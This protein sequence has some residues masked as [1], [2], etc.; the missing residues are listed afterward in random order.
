VRE[1]TEER[2][3][4]SVLFAD[5]VGFTT[6]SD[7]ADPEDV[8]AAL[9]PYYPRVKREIERVG[10]RV[11]KYIGDAVVGFFGAPLAREDDAERAVRAALAI[12]AAIQELN[13]Q[14]AGLDLA[15]RVAVNTG[16]AMVS[17]GALLE[18]G[19]GMVAGDVVNTASRLQSIAPVGQVVVGELTYQATR[20][21]IDYQPMDPVSVKGKSHPVEVWLAATVRG[22]L[23]REVDESPMVGRQHELQLLLRL[24]QQAVEEH[25]PHL[26][27]I[28]GPP[29][30]GKSR[31]VREVTASVESGDARVLRG[32]CRAYGETTGYEAFGQ[33]VQQAAG[34]LETDTAAEARRKL[35]ERVQ[36]LE[37]GDDAKEVADHLAV[38]LGLPSD[39]SPDKTVL[40]YSARRFA[41]AMARKQP[42][43]L[44]VEDIHWAG[45]PLLDLLESL[46]ARCR[47]IPLLLVTTARPELLDIR[48]TWGGGLSSYAAVPLAPLAEATSRQLA[49]QLFARGGGT[50]VGLDSLIETSGGNPLFIEELASSLAEQATGIAAAL[51]ATVQAIIAARLDGLPSEERRVLQDASVIGGTFWR[52]VLASL[53]HDESELDAALDRLEVR[54]FVRRQPTSR[55]A[56]DREFVFK[57]ILTREVAYGTLPRARRRERHA[58]VASYIERVVGDRAAES[59][60]ILAHHWMESGEETRALPH[61]L[62]AAEIS[63]RAWAKQAADA[64]YT[65]AIGVAERLG[66]D[67]VARQALLDRA[68]VRI[69]GGDQTGAAEDLER[70]LGSE[71]TDEQRA[72][73]L[74]LRSRAAYWLAD[75]VGVKTYAQ[76]AA[77]AA[78][79]LSNA[80]IEARAHAVLA[81]LAGMEGDLPKAIDLMN[82]SAAG[83]PADSSDPD[84]AYGLGLGAVFHYWRGE[85]QAAVDMAQRGF[86]LGSEASNVAAVLQAASNLGMS[87]VGLSR[88]EEG[89]EWFERGIRLGRELEPAMRLTG[90]MVNMW[91]GSLRE[92]GDLEASRERSAEGLEMGRMAN[93]PGAVVSAQIDL[94]FTD[95]AEGD[96]GR[97]AAAVP[98]LLE[99]V[100]ATKGWHQWLWG[101]RL[102]AAQAEIA[103]AS[104][105]A[106]D[107]VALAAEALD[108]AGRQGRLKYQ[109]RSRTLMGE[110]LFRV[111]QFEEAAQVFSAATVEADGL[112]HAPSQWSALGGLSRTLDQLGR[113]EQAARALSDARGTVEKFATGLRDER[114]TAFLASPSA[115]LLSLVSA[116]D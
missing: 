15:V 109:C 22:E 7:R 91:A 99:Q 86:D 61:L 53:G 48:P 92:L 19:E 33:Q 8:Q 112:G 110:A 105:H 78:R 12:T 52:G 49:R 41:E 59:A 62:T 98:E 90:R 31:L 113:D 36:A 115:R 13:D 101:G 64:L 2:K 1:R 84:F 55:V 28:M 23:E 83:W 11:E 20:H 9:R 56:G 21:A 57:H 100:Q 6:R 108:K 34:I 68:R 27:T 73:A 87:L 35:D 71:L 82:R 26:V 102:A 4:V 93:F 18:E 40:F 80:D 14:H 72:V 103:L 63:S 94:L 114:R 10:G 44:V 24:W 116:P 51:P 16:E 54:D 45:T 65:Q 81:E 66:N 79:R 29:G 47:D 38:L 106:A 111:G 17:V 77:A 74:F 39:V 5:L 43:V 46:A 30:I 42:T 75:A 104:G 85:Y 37:L 69:E 89:L 3:V 32:R 97:A 107:A 88:T 70:L 76:E 50:Q 25:R 67:G 95:L 96:V 58:D 60:S